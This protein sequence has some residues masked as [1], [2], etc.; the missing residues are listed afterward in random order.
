MQLSGKYVG[1]V[2][3]GRIGS[4]VAKRLEAFGCHLSYF[5]RTRKPS[6]SYKYF[7]SVTELAAENDVLVVSCAL[8]DETY[9]IINK[10]VMLALGRNGFII[11]IGRGKLVDEKELVDCL[12]QGDIGGAGLDVFENEPS[13]P[14]ELIS[15]DNVVLSPHRAV[16]TPESSQGLIELVVG[17]LEA[18]FRNE[19][20]VSPISD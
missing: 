10:E 19:P 8:T 20:L 2:G 18:F 13:V 1:I 5:S 14:Q 6:V 15:M 12:M 9:H 11:N 3:L 4:A 17:N 7:E 16:M